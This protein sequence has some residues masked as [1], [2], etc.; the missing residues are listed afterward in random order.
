MVLEANSVGDLDPNE[1][2]VANSIT[3]FLILPIVAAKATSRSK[4]PIVDF[5]KSVMLIPKIPSVFLPISAVLTYLEESI[6]IPKK[7]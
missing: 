7:V 1:N 2:D 4:D 5:S 6:S 3:K